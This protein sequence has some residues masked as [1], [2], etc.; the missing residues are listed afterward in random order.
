MGIALIMYIVFNIIALMNL[1]SAVF[2]ENAIR[3]AEVLKEQTQV[4]QARRVFQALD[5]DRSGYISLA[6]M[7]NHLEEQ[8]VQDFFESIDV[9]P[10]DVHWLFDLLDTD[11]TGTIAFE[12]FLTGC[13]RL[14]GPAKAMDLILITREMRRAFAQQ[15]AKQA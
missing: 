6:E 8:D 13:L 10:S 15:A 14:Q 4:S 2:V 1:I 5:V 3:Q 12:E 7:R 11:D 9:D